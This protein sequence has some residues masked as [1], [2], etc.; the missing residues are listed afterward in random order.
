MCSYLAIFRK[1]LYQIYFHFL[2]HAVASFL[3]RANYLRDKALNGVDD[4][5]HCFVIF[6]DNEE[7]QIKGS[8]ILLKSCLNE[9]PCDEVHVM[10]GDI[11]G[12]YDPPSY[13]EFTKSK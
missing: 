12:Q 1:S 9:V 11:F 8:E 3:G 4:Y 13:Y 6:I 5:Q 2:L 7:S 10:K